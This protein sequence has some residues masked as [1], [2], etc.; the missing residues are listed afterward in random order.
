MNF[1]PNMK[2]PALRE[3]VRLAIIEKM[4][5]ANVDPKSLKG[6]EKQSQFVDEETGESFTK[7]KLKFYGVTQVL[8]VDIPGQY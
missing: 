3:A 5:A 1:L 4:V 6:V 7:I 2:D 8:V